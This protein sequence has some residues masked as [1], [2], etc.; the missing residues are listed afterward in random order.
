[1]RVEADPGL[2]EI[3]PVRAWSTTPDFAGRINAQAFRPQTLTATS[4]D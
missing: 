4:I 1:M 2:V 3:E